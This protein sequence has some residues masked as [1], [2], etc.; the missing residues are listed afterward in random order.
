VHDV[1][2]GRCD[3]SELF[4]RLTPGYERLLPEFGG[5]TAGA[6]SHAPVAG[7]TADR[8][9]NSEFERY[10]LFES[11]C[12]LFLNIARSSA[13]PGL[14][15]TLDDLHWADGPTLQ[16]LMHFIRGL[17]AASLLL[18]G[19][20][21]T[22]EVDRAH[23]LTDMLAE[24]SRE[25]TYQRVMLAPLPRDDLTALVT[26]LGGI[27]PA[28]VVVDAIYHQT[29]GNPFFVGEI[30]RHLQ[31]QQRDLT[32]SSTATG[33][34]DVP[35]GV[36]RVIGKRLAR[37]GPDANLL[38]QA[39]AVL[40]E[41]FTFDLLESMLDS[42]TAPL[43]DALEEA[44]RSGLIREEGPRYHFS[45]ALVR[46]TLYD[47]L[48]LPRRQRLHLQAAAAIER[49]YAR[50]LGPHFGE[51]AVHY[52][53]SGSVT[54]IAR[55]VDYSERAGDAAIKLLAYEEAATHWQAALELMA[56]DDV[57]IP[58]RARLLE[59]LGELLFIAGLDYSLGISA[60]E[61]ALQLYESLGLHAESAQIH[62][63][64]GRALSS[65]PETWDIPRAVR[66]FR[67]AQAILAQASD[68]S[69]LGYVHAGLA[70]AAIWDVHVEDGLA[71]SLAA[72]EL[73]ERMQDDALWHTL[74]WSTVGTCARA[75]GWPRAR[76]SRN[77]PGK[78]PTDE[79]T[80]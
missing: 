74:P 20:Y 79:T 17:T 7:Q 37:L 25:H 60:M 46:Q 65:V 4:H 5:R 73:A 72:M 56:D 22:V 8:H 12:G 48:T 75:V 33:K 44:L 67:A 50:S 26:S 71:S 36:H 31:E 47:G 6:V 38:L 32:D 77:V 61:Q 45:H 69:A 1:I 3:R 15:V 34:W 64:L 42:E 14:L 78:V 28:T 66:H 70:Q 40:G 21:R 52:R 23:P 30:V 18:V 55:A 51:V 59:R 57:G 54:D 39:S 19:S 80:P 10:Q 62:A 76:S 9:L 43:L 11:V 24:L 58:H 16:L 63:R 27:A 49:V 13:P 41:P 29:N 35:E 2:A 53:L 68:T